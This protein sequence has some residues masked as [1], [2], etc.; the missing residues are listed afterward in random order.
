MEVIL[1]AS[2]K[3][4]TGKTSFTAAVGAALA[5]RGKKVLAID[6]DCGLRNLDLALG[7]ADRVVFSFADVVLR[8]VPLEHAL[9]AH[10]VYE[11]LHLLT[12]PPAFP[13]LPAEGLSSLVSQ[14][15]RAGFDYLLID[16]PAGLPEE[17]AAY[18]AIARRGVVIT[19]PDAASIRGAET[20]AR[21]LEACGLADDMLVV[22][23]IRTRLI[24]F[25]LA[26]NMDDAMDAAGLPLLGMIPED[27]DILAC[28]GSGKSI[29]ALKKRGAA[30]AYRNI[31]RR[32]CGEYVPLMR[33]R[34]S[35]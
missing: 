28:A 30:R 20:V 19:Q 25:G 11:Q 7:M 3:G 8:G 32:L 5:E 9:C 1:T 16:G 12:A 24:R 22:N 4:G 21:R 15:E 13:E 35:F 29:L 17:L 26:S 10:P 33:L 34:G 2:G 18:A 31:A 14:A 23:R 27:E 6:G